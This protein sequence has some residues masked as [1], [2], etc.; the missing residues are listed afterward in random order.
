MALV[1]NCAHARQSIRHR[2]AA[3][4]RA[5][6]LHAEVEQNLCDAA[7]AYA[8]DADEVRVLGGSKHKVL[9]STLSLMRLPGRHLIPE[10]LRFATV[11]GENGRADA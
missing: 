6:N 2:P 4:I 11:I 8:A 1:D 9:N 3:Q 5:R 10:F 7:H